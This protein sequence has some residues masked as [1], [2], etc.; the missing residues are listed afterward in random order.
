M[1]TCPNCMGER[2]V[3]ENHPDK[4]SNKEGCECGAGMPCPVCNDVKPPDM[5]ALPPDFHIDQVAGVDGSK[6]SQK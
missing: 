1:T 3:C 2:W 6:K 4:P 5:P